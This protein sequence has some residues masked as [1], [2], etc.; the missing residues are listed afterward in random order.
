VNNSVG[1][2]PMI[3]AAPEAEDPGVSGKF[4]VSTS[5]VAWRQRPR[6]S[7]KLVHIP[8]GPNAKACHWS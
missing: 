5:L 8:P 1:M 2:K 6:P 7:H 4:L 3:E